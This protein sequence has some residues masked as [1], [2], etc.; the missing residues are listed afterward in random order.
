MSTRLADD[1]PSRARDR[2]TTSERAG[3][4]GRSL[5]DWLAISWED[6]IQLASLEALDLLRIRTRNST[7]DVAVLD[8]ATGDVLVRGGR[9]F[10]E[11]TRGRLLGCSFGRG[12]LRCRTVQAGMRLELCAGG[13][14]VVTS[15]VTAAAQ[16]RA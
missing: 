6:S 10:P 2:H 8:P 9:Y 3:E 1:S 15:T 11:W 16:C 14:H 5:A 7:Y 13:R 4:Y 12:L